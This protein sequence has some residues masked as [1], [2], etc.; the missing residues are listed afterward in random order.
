VHRPARQRPLGRGPLLATA[1]STS[2][3]RRGWRVLEAA[4][5]ARA[6]VGRVLEAAEE[7]AV[8]LAVKAI[9]AL[10]GGAGRRRRTGVLRAAVGAEANAARLDS[11]NTAGLSVGAEV[12]A[13][14]RALLPIARGRRE[15][16]QRRQSVAEEEVRRRRTTITG[17]ETIAGAAIAAS[18]QLP[19]ADRHPVAVGSSQSIFRPCRC[20]CRRSSPRPTRPDRGCRRR[21][22]ARTEQDEE[23]DA[24]VHRWDHTG[25]G[26]RRLPASGSTE[27]RAAVAGA[28]AKMPRMS[29]SRVWLAQ[30]VLL[31]AL[32]GCSSGRLVISLDPPPIA[33]L[34]P[35]QDG[36]LSKFGLRVTY[37]GRAPIRTRFAARR[38]SSPS[39]TCPPT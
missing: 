4:E 35:L 38:A 27:G 36:R 6:L 29:R 10:R 32:G 37:N 17:A 19:L 23:Q 2:A 26:V 28:H 31:A 15:V 33:E 1:A 9:E 16:G 8:R 25:S 39:A 24:E 7:G 13:G 18:V 3:G 34:D 30:L 12:S 11:R 21:R 20:L 22:A 14:Q 5:T